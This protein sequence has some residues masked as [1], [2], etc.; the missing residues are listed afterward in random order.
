MLAFS[1]V[2]FLPPGFEKRRREGEMS[3]DGP[4]SL[5]MEQCVLGC[6][7]VCKSNPTCPEPPRRLSYFSTLAIDY[8]STAADT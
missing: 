8:Y 5:S 3:G 6:S 4:N 2:C 1:I 7:D